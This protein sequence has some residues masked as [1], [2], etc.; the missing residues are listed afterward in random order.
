MKTREIELYIHIPFC[1]RKCNYC[2]FCSFP[3]GEAKIRSY[4]EQLCREIRSWKEEMKRQRLA[5]VFIGGGTPSILQEAWILRM[6]EAVWDTFQQTEGIEVTIEANP[7]TVTRE[8]LHAYR[9]AGINRISFGLQSMQKK[10]LEY[11]GRIHDRKDFLESYENARQEGF[12]NINVDL[13]SGIPL[14]TLSSFERTLR[15][16]AQLEP[17]HISAYSL[18]V[19]EGTAFA[20][21]PK[22][23]QLL[24]SEGD[25]VKMY[26]MTGEI[27]EDY[28]YHKYEISNYAK[29]EMECRHNL[30]YWSQ[31]P[32]L[33]VGLFASSYL[34]GKRFCQTRSMDEYLGQKDF[35]KEYHIAERQT[36]QEEMEEFMFLGLRKTKG[37][38]E[39]DFQER[40]GNSMDSVYG[41]V[42]Q[43][44]V[45]NG[46]LKREKENIS[47]TEQG[48]LFSNQVLCDFL[49]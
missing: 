3:A 5:T 34:D 47:L 6:M 25:D 4:M 19:E 36:E 27:L 1:V 21:D 49:L 11:L 35:Q 17:E 22:L 10:E 43:E 37:V 32:Y 26:E 20:K 14:Q 24:P 41:N 46:F 9:Q 15:E 2:D 48:I 8:K 13:M 45:Q 29:D 16:T 38:S 42:I 30:G 33:G 39:V 44:A 7:G 31:I 28:G 23:E 18:I 12:Q 40:F